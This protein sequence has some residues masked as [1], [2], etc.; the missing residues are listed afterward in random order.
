[1]DANCAGSQDVSGSLGE[2]CGQQISVETWATPGMVVSAASVGPTSICVSIGS[3]MSS[4]AAPLASEGCDDTASQAA[5]S[6][7]DSTSAASDTT[8]VAQCHP[9][10]HLSAGNLHFP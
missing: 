8:S 10:L 9:T 7:T 3:D 4:A 1:M 5:L 2:H 6:V